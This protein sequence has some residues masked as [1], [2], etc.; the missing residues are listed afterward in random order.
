MSFSRILISAKAAQSA[1]GVR[2]TQWYEWLNSG[3]MVAPVPIGVRQKR[4]PENEVQAVINARIAGRSEDQIRQ[5]VSKLHADRL[6]SL[7]VQS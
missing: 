3:L 1:S 5:L 4:Y 6:A 7:A 2:Q